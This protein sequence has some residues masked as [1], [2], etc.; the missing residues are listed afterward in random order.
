M[1]KFSIKHKQKP[2]DTQLSEIKVWGFWRERKVSKFV[3]G[4]SALGFLVF[5]LFLIL[6]VFCQDTDKPDLLKEASIA[7]TNIYGHRPG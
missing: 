2:D 1:P 4:F 5:C 3:C 7:N 6:K